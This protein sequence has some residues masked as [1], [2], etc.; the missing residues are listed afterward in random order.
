MKFYQK[1]IYNYKLE[2]DHTEGKRLSD[3]LEL[4]TIGDRG[5]NWYE[6]INF[7]KDIAVTFLVLMLVLPLCTF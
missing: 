4:M 7:F 3:F 2:C 1:N 5:S 6:M